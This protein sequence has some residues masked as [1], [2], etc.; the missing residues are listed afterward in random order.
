MTF[1]NSFEG[2]DSSIE[3]NG[4]IYKNPFHE[5]SEESENEEGTRVGEVPR[6]QSEDQVDE[7]QMN[8]TCN[9]SCFSYD[10]V[11]CDECGVKSENYIGQWVQ[12]TDCDQV[13]LCEKCHCE[14]LARQE[15]DE[16]DGDGDVTRQN[17]NSS[18]TVPL[19]DQDL[20]EVATPPV[21]NSS[22][23]DPLSDQDLG[24]VAT[25]KSKK[26]T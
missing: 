23:T 3:H 24:E 4:F 11:T 9:T 13:Y 26:T 5:T 1:E 8:S 18:S 10:S 15:A 6:A 21:S 14:G 12:S 2:S 25:C 7:D 16:L 22:S 17:S 20:G 19:S